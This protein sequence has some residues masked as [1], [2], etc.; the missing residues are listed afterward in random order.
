[1]SEAR[2]PDNSKWL[3]CSLFYCGIALMAVRFILEHVKPPYNLSVFSWN[4]VS[5]FWNGSGERC[6]NWW[7]Q[8]F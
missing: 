2:K 5:D 1:M 4:W 6:E 7:P 3:K 8:A